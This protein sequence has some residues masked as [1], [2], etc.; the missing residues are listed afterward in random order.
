VLKEIRIWFIRSKKDDN[1]QTLIK[2]LNLNPKSKQAKF[3]GAAFAIGADK[4]RVSQL[5]KGTESQVYSGIEKILTHVAKHGLP[6][7][8][9]KIDCSLTA[10]NIGF[11]V[12][13]GKTPGTLGLDELLKGLNGVVVREEIVRGFSAKKNIAQDDLKVGDI[14]RWAKGEDNKATHFA[15]FIYTDDNGVPV[16]FSKSGV[17]GRYEY[18]PINDPR[19]SQKYD[20]GS[21]R[22]IG[23]NETGFYRPRR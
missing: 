5:G 6:A 21:I 4:F 13:M 15:N 14:V 23:T 10:C 7:K 11:G 3:I 22:G 2:Q 1:A 12:D 16:V 18:A 20:Y 19:W 9:E 17:E 8:S